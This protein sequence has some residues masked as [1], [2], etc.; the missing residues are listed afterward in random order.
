MKSTRSPIFLLITL[1]VLQSAEVEV[2]PV[3]TTEPPLLDGR[4]SEQVWQKTPRITG[5]KTVEPEFGKA[6]TEKT[7]AYAAYDD[8]NL[9][10]ALECYDSEP[11][12]VKATVA[13]WDQL[14]MGQQD[15]AGVVIDALN[16]Q[17]LALG[18]IVNA[19]GSQADIALGP[20]GDGD[21]TPDFIWE[22]GGLLHENGYTVELAIPLK[23]LRYNTGEEVRMGLAFVRV[24]SRRSETSVYPELVPEKGAMTAQLVSAVYTDLG[25]SRT[26]EVLPSVTR[27][28]TWSQES[29]RLARNEN[30]SRS[31]LKDL[32]RYGLGLTGKVGL[33]PTLTM[34]LTLNPDFS[35]VES[36][37]GQIDVNI[38]AP[39]FF[40]EKRPFFQEGLDNFT[41]G[42]QG[43]GAIDRMV[44]TRNIIDPSVG[45]KISGKLG[46]A[47][48]LTALLASDESPLY[49]DSV[50]TGQTAL[51]RIARYKRILKEDA[52][53]GGIVTSREYRGGYNRVAGI[54]GRIR[55]SG[56]LTLEGNALRSS[57]RA[58]AADPSRAADNLDL[59]L[60]YSDRNWYF[61]LGYHHT[62]TLFTLAS[63]YI[64]RD[65]VRRLGWG[66]NRNFYPQS[67]IL[68]R[69]TLGYGGNSG[70][71]LYYDLSEGR[72]SGFLNLAL[73]RST[74][75]GFNL[76]NGNEAWDGQL[77]DDSGYNFY[78][79]S[80]ILKFLST[81]AGF[82][83]GYT[84]L[85]DESLQGRYLSQW[86]G[87]TFQPNQN[88]TLALS[89]YLQ[90]FHQTGTGEELYQVRIYRLRTTYQVNKYLLA[91]LIS[92]YDTYEEHLLT[93]FLLSF[94]YIPGTV[95]HLGYASGFD[96]QDWD[97]SE[98]I[99]GKG[100]LETSRGVFLKASYNWRL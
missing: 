42:G 92:E 64:P 3:R 75:T 6:A 49:N 61:D 96:R 76:W 7:V 93:E 86:G 46:A 20:N 54:D 55:F 70:Q 95:I 84:P 52:F 1:T 26:V 79:T 69:I 59:S 80:Q 12:K 58:V 15:W 23:S 50:N 81:Y 30:D 43:T 22:A 8:Q 21:S 29:G 89:A 36:D 62:D 65:G 63:G 88:Y 87:L 31:A 74:Y 94:T 17:Q 45:A 85:Y 10:F 25:Y 18:F 77:F 41:I 72:H 40:S 53:L 82:S 48:A 47:H 37:A 99:P 68:K 16:D 98:Y 97:G 39:L 9:Y 2:V 100:F 67:G 44:H 5:F 90:V 11:G 13:N 19:Y 38:R 28:L 57:T 73:V 24:I 34:D 35:Q 51:F 4:L 32:D 14:L 78:F 66:F 60:N 56:T 83:R 71:D 33:T 27:G 91:R